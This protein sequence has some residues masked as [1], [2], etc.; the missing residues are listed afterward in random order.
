MKYRPDTPLVLRR[1][2]FEVP[3]GLKIGVVG[4][5]GAGKSS[6][7]VAISRIAELQSGKIV[8]D[9][10]D[11]ASLELSELRSRITVIEQDPTLFTGT[12]RFN[13]DPFN[14]V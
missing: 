14:E 10:V 5:T 7:L 12:L 11:I 8:V 9:G 3:A 4:R 1:L 13:L 6:M 2:T